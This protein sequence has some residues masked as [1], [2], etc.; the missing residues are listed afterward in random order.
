MNDIE[1]RYKLLSDVREMLIKQWEDKQQVER[2]TAEF[3]ERAPKK[4]NLPT[5]RRI[6]RTAEELFD[7]VKN[8]NQPDRTKPDEAAAAEFEADPEFEIE[9]ADILEDEVDPD[10]EDDDID[11]DDDPDTDSEG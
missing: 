8:I 6:M 4:V 1:L 9:V 7:F 10:D 2:A 5:V 3:E 11:E